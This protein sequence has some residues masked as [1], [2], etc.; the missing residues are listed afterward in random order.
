M[1]KDFAA[2]PVTDLKRFVFCRPHGGLNDIFCQLELCWSYAER[3]DR[4]LILDGSRCG[5]LGSFSAFFAPNASRIP[6]FTNITPELVGHI[7]SLTCLPSS[8]QG[9][10]DTCFS[11]MEES[12]DTMV[13]KES[14]QELT[15]DMDRDYPEQVL[16]HEQPGGG[17]LSHNGLARVVLAPETLPV[18]EEALQKLPDKYVGIH[19]RNTDLRTAYGDLF[20]EIFV[21]VTGRNVVL[22]SDDPTVVSFGKEYFNLSK[23]ISISEPP[24]L[25]GKPIHSPWCNTDGA[26]RRAAVLSSIVDL[27][28]LGGAE[29]VYFTKAHDGRYSGFARLAEFISQNKSVRDSLLGRT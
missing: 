24:N 3:F 15:F 14:G 11:I 2:V 18:I 12:T 16:V 28:A 27:L 26:T 13:V 10:I 19:V 25:G 17:T 9:R 4:A 23:V 20:Q 22:C 8:I 6:V 21:K 29:K 1:L 7:N 5:M